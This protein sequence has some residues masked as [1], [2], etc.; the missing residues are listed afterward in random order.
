MHPNRSL[1]IETKEGKGDEPDVPPVPMNTLQ[2]V[3]YSRITPIQTGL[4]L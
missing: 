3:L 4:F 1:I 2:F